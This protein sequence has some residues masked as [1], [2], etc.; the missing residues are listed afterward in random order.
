MGKKLNN[1]AFLFGAGISQ[2]AGIL[3]VS[4]ITGNIL[5]AKNVVYLNGRWYFK[6]SSEN[7]SWTKTEERLKRI[8]S[9]FDIIKNDLDQFYIQL[10]REMNYEDYYYICD[11]INEDQRLNY[12]NS[13]VAYYDQNLYQ[14]FP[15]IFGEINESK[16]NQL[17]TD[18]TSDAKKYIEDLVIDSLNKEPIT[19]KHLDFLSDIEKDKDISKI[20]LF[21]LNHDNFLEKFFQSKKIEYSDGFVYGN[22]KCKI[23]NPDSFN[24]KVNILK[25]HGSIDWY[26]DS[27]S[28][29]YDA[30]YYKNLVVSRENGRPIVLMGS[31]N[32]L[33]Q[34][35]RSIYFDLLC[36][37]AQKLESC[38]YLVVGGYSFGD[39][40]INTRI[41]E[42]MFKSQLRKLI[43]IH[44]K[45]EELRLRSRPA[46]RD[47][48]SYLKKKNTILNIKKYINIEDKLEWNE[49]K[50][51]MTL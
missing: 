2:P 45:E 39:Q 50:E 30:H 28:D 15:N 47:K 9:L 12:E 7:F 35:S 51:Q 37:F 48:W 42:W 43:V 29:W 1:I 33:N 6:N 32:K 21:T 31:F 24:F 36:L 44:S 49:L 34:Y 4:E 14:R 41:I 5:N 25:L 23:W 17:L 26:Y 19:L 16:N 22:A 8:K 11:S 18:I 13:I 40:G 10:N 27:G 38:N 20:Y 3:N 46:I